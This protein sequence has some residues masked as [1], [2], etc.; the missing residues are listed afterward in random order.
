MSD[1]NRF[2]LVDEPWIPIIGSSPVSL[3]QLFTER[4]L[5]LGGNPIQK[6]ALLKLLL[7]IAQAAYTPEDDENWHALGVNGMAER[8]LAY[9]GQWRHKFW[10]YGSEPFLQMPAIEHDKKV[11]FGVVMPEI[12]PKNNSVLFQ[13]QSEQNLNDAQKAILIITLM[14]FGM[15]NGK[16]NNEPERSPGTW[17]GKFGYLH[18]FLVGEDLLETI[19]FNLLTI[20]SIDN[21]NGVGFPPWENM[22]KNMDCPIA[23]TLKN[24]LIGRLVPLSRFCL[25]LNDGLYYSEGIVHPTPDQGGRDPSLA[26]DYLTSKVMLVDSS[27][28]PW[29]Q[30]SSMLGFLSTGH[31][32]M[33]SCFQLSQGLTRARKTSPTIR[34]WSGGLKATT[35]G[36]K[37]QKVSGTDDFVQS[38]IELRSSWLGEIWYLQLQAQMDKLEKLSEELGKS[39][40]KYFKEQNAKG[41]KQAK[42]A[43]SLYWQFCEKEF[44]ALLE[45][46][47]E[48]GSGALDALWRR[49]IEHARASFDSL[50]PKDTVR[51]LDAWTKHRSSISKFMNKKTKKKHGN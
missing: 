15:A 25:L 36:F 33:W 34:I 31:K 22:P 7:A 46:C 40:R 8:C 35:S 2:N 9:L 30:L 37:D 50:C 14:G 44:R 18:N 12:G 6:I 13:S 43:L 39:V 41:G 19:W 24:S 38:M 28:R 23:T 42:R 51:Q 32:S 20:S 29:R 10:L 21:R 45:A 16:K 27:K 5:D 1:I 26:I 47:N 3:E 48:T 49:Y 11:S 4:G 17:M